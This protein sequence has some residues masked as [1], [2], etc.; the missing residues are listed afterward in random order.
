MSQGERDIS[1]AEKITEPDQIKEHSVK[2]K[3]LGGDGKM[4]G[5]YVYRQ[6]VGR[7]VPLGIGLT[8]NPA[9]DVKGIA[10]KKTLVEKSNKKEKNIS[11][12]TKTSVKKD[13]KV[14]KINS[15]KDI[16]DENLKEMSASVV[17][18]FVEN[19]LKK[20]SE[21]YSQEKSKYDEAIKAA[22]QKAAE[23]AEQH[24]T[25]EK[26]FDEV[27]SQLEEMKAEEAE[28][29]ALELFSSRMT[30]LD[31]ELELSDADRGV[32]ASQIKDLDEEGFASFMKDVKVLMSSK[33]RSGESQAAVYSTPK[34]KEKTEK[35]EEAAEEAAEEVIEGAVEEA[36]VEGEAVANT[37]TPEEASMTDKYK[38]AFNL[39]GF[40]IK[41]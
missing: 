12:S 33:V 16:T 14:M 27:K 2:L 24:G 15:I 23:L 35:T 5:K 21:D 37:I 19:E 38:N 26:S 30:S 7:I 10:T 25:L 18:E 22:D 29:E 28:R 39:D 36:E 1:Y 20:A 4:N 11:E 9:A 41:Y 13:N 34:V 6:V 8:E 40:N 32:L 17:S 31:H 3:A